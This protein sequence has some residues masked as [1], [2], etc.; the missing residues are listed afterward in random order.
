MNDVYSERPFSRETRISAWFA[1]SNVV[2]G[3]ELPSNLV[4]WPAFVERSVLK[5]GEGFRHKNY[6]RFAVEIPLEGSLICEARGETAEI[7]PGEI[8]L[9]HTKLLS[10]SRN[11]F[12]DCS[13]MY[14]SF[15][16]YDIT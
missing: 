1:S 15:R 2:A 16:Y 4:L 13:Q 6:T 11:S 8:F 7:R 5:P 14:P 3:K 12:I 9:I 10:K